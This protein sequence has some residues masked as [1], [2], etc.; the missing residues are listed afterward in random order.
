MKLTR[1][2]EEIHEDLQY[3]LRGVRF[4]YVGYTVDRENYAILVLNGASKINS[5][6]EQRDAALLSGA[7]GATTVI[8]SSGELVL[9]G[10]NRVLENRMRDFLIKR[11]KP[12][13][14]DAIII[15]TDESQLR[16]E[17]GAVSSALTLY[18]S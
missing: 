5:G 18:M 6:V 3:Y 2:G 13:K 8:N 9:P 12:G 14:G 4:P 17:I 1:K 15:G 16:A 11:L 7:K 10:I